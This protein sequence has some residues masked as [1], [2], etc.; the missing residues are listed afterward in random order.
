M[1]NMN[2]STTD[3][4]N[5]VLSVR[6]PYNALTN[7]NEDL[8]VGISGTK[9]G[10]FANI[11]NAGPSQVKLALDL[12]IWTVI[13]AVD[14][15]RGN[16]LGPFVAD[17]YVL[18]PFDT[19]C[20]QAYSG[21][22]HN[23]LHAVTGGDKNSLR[24]APAFTLD[25]RLRIAKITFGSTGV[26]THN[27]VRACLQPFCAVRA[28]G[29]SGVH[30][31]LGSRHHRRQLRLRWSPAPGVD[32]LPF[33]TAATLGTQLGDRAPP[34]R[35]LRPVRLVSAT[36]TPQTPSSHPNISTTDVLGATAHDFPTGSGFPVS[37]A[38]GPA[39]TYP[40]FARYPY[41]FHR[42]P[43]IEAATCSYDADGQP[44]GTDTAAHDICTET[45]ISNSAIVDVDVTVQ[46][47][48]AEVLVG[49]GIP[50]GATP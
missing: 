4:D 35:Q 49:Q 42:S 40:W 33:P 20:R 48:T 11:L 16:G 17:N 14:A 31:Q 45:G 32:D 1:P 44:T 7:P 3:R 39:P 25:R 10:G 47:V 2:T 28:G 8:L 23:V 34:Q 41:N 21:Y 50:S 30:L 37:E 13:R 29:H 43:G 12:N 22:T 27:T 26:T 24:I 5:T 36:T 6:G 38:G 9:S 15:E 19:N 46:N 18:D